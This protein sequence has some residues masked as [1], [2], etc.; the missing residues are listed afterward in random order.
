[1][2]VDW[3]TSNGDHGEPNNVDALRHLLAVLAV[4]H[5]SYRRYDEENY[6]GQLSS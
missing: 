6:V 4:Q 3:A 2:E 1:M 5:D